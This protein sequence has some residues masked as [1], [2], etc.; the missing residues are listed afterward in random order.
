MQDCSNKLTPGEYRLKILI[1]KL[2]IHNIRN[3][4]SLN[5]QTNLE[6]LFTWRVVENKHIM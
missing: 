4:S 5:S 3:K 1:V 6:R 2:L